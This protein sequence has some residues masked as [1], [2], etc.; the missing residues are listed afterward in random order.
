MRKWSHIVTS[1][2]KAHIHSTYFKKSIVDLWLGGA[3]GMRNVG[4]GRMLG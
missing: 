4:L 3:S 1:H 2:D